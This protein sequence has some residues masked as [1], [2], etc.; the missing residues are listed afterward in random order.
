MD[1]RFWSKVDKAGTP[2]HPWCWVW[3]ASRKPAGY[4]QLRRRGK[5][6]YAHRVAYESLVETIPSG[7]TL[8]HLC[9]NRACVNPVHLEPVSNEEN[10]RRGN[11]PA[12]ARQVAERAWAKRR[13]QTHCKR[14]HALDGDNVRAVGGRRHCRACGRQ[15]LAS[16]AESKN[17]RRRQRRAAP[18]S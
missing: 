6:L 15:S 11:H 2:E 16:T 9:R 13:A 1:E 8:D 7:L 12:P 17:A 3:I 10:L 5:T 14:G 4:G 18:R